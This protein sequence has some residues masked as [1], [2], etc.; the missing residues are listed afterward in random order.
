[1]QPGE[2]DPDREPP[3]RVHVDQ[4]QDVGPRPERR[5]RELLWVESVSERLLGGQAPRP[6]E[7]VYFDRDA[8]ADPVDRER[9]NT[10]DDAPAEPDEIASG[11]IEHESEPSQVPDATAPEEE[12]EQLP[13]S[14]EDP[15]DEEP[16][17]EAP[18]AEEPPPALDDAASTPGEDPSVTFPTTTNEGPAPV[19][20]SFN[21]GRYG[22]TEQYAATPPPA[23]VI[24]LTGA[25]PTDDE[26]L[27]AALVSGD[28]TLAGAVVDLLDSRAR[29]RA[30]VAS[31]ERALRVLLTQVERSPDSIGAGTAAGA[32]LAAVLQRVLSS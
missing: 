32:S 14:V 8:D 28:A 24:D 21:G 27:H 25:A 17:A 7:R 22:S 29:D 12:P 1:V 30:R 3:E 9:A 19:S 31:L 26:I 10:P 23:R 4:A 18:T 13:P 16:I 5:E 6:W 20:D 15:T 2:Q 11:V